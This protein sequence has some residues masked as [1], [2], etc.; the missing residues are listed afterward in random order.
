MRL[1]FLKGKAHRLTI[2][3]NAQSAYFSDDSTSHDHNQASGDTIQVYFRD[4]KTAFL[5]I[6]GGVRGT[7]FAE[8]PGK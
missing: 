4:G 1:D 3:G 7:Y 5:G 2:S 8:T 6:R